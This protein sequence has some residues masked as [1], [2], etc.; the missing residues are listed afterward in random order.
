MTRPH[1]SRLLLLLLGA[2][3]LGC[4]LLITTV[5]KAHA[6]SA[7]D[8]YLE[9]N[10]DGKGGKGG[11]SGSAG[12]GSS[13]GSR[14]GGSSSSGS[15]GSG[16]S[17]SGGDAGYD[18]SGNAT[19]DF[20]GDGAIDASDDKIAA[21]KKKAKKEK[22]KKDDAV[23]GAASN[24]DHGGTGGTGGS[25]SSPELANSNVPADEGGSGALWIVLALLLAGPIAVMV[26]WR[27]GPRNKRRDSGSSEPQGT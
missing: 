5:T 7:V 16:G 26:W 17:G 8:Q 23:S 3:A 19:R 11:G 21:K 24:G 14:S 6:Q 9:S 13:S 2:I 15:G 1:G 25:A 27:F 12:G 22:E 10:P 4:A 20:N 18:A